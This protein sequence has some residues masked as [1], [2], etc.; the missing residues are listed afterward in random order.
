MKIS[1]PRKEGSRDHIMFI[2]A[3][4]SAPL[5]VEKKRRD[6]A[7]CVKL[8]II[9]VQLG[10]GTSVRFCQVPKNSQWVRNSLNEMMQEGGGTGCVVGTP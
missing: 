5:R 10:D 9:S 8:R 6:L 7:I 3:V 2:Q 1:D 4:T